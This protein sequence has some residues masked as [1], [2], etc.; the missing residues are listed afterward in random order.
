MVL[1]QSID[2]K[3]RVIYTKL[4]AKMKKI[5]FRDTDAERFLETRDYCII[6]ESFRK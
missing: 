3:L 2:D 1:F 6:K 4:I 5:L